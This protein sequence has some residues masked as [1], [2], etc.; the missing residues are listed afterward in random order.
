MSLGQWK[1]L[2]SVGQWKDLVSV[3]QERILTERIKT[4]TDIIF[5]QNFKF[6]HVFCFTWLITDRTF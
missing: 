4:S 6:C 3:G 2:V 1:D 5:E